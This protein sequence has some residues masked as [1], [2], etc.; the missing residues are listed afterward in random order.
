MVWIFSPPG[1]S[2]A[3]ANRARARGQVAAGLAELGQLA[4]AAAASSTTA[5]PPSVSNSRRCISAAAALV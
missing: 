1:V 3:R 2:S 5:Q 4:V